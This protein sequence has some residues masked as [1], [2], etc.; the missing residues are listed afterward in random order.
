MKRVY[1]VSSETLN[2]QPKLVSAKSK[3]SAIKHVVGNAVNV[4]IADKAEIIRFLGDGGS[5][6]DS[7]E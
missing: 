6:E 1:I 3:A 5:V 2:I 4:K 7:S